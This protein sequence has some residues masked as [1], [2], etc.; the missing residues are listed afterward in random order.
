VRSY[1]SLTNHISSKADFLIAVAT[2]IDA[3]SKI[4][5]RSSNFEILPVEQS[6]FTNGSLKLMVNRFTFL[7]Q[8]GEMDATSQGVYHLSGK[9]H[10]VHY[11]ADVRSDAET[12]YSGTVFHAMAFIPQEIQVSERERLIDAMRTFIEEMDL[13]YGK[14]GR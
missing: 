2:Q 13:S 4:N 5:V 1:D 6:C 11:L 10:F 14:N 3:Q 9:I 7:H 8:E 12:N